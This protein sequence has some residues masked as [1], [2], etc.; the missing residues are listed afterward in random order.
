[1]ADANLTWTIGP[2]SASCHH[3]GWSEHSG[4]A[5]EEETDEFR[6][7]VYQWVAASP[8]PVAWFGYAVNGAPEGFVQS[9]DATVISAVELK[10]KIKG[11][12]ENNLLV[13]E[14]T[15]IGMTRDDLVSSLG[16]C[17]KNARPLPVRPRS[18]VARRL[19][20]LFCASSP[21]RASSSTTSLRL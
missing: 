7:A 18:R 10:I 14:D 15:G 6:Y 21:V 19:E 1:M 9:S 5:I 11:D 12:K 4:G 3:V 2:A 8:Q 20:C 16:A 17:T 13:V